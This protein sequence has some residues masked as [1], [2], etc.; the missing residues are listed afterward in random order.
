MEDHKGL[1][2]LWRN[3]Q[4]T[5]SEVTTEWLA[6]AISR[7]RTWFGSFSRRLGSSQQPNQVESYCVRSSF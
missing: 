5:R 2:V 1:A 4:R 7:S 3:A 6:Q